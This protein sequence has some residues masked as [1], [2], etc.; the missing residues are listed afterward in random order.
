MEP[1]WNLPQ[2]SPDQ[3]EE[4]GEPWW[5]PRLEH[6][7]LVELGGTLVEP[8]LKPPRTKPSQMVEPWWNPGG[9]LVEPL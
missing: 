2:T 1:L 4:I 8:Y 7:G 5:N 6:K 3:L 9:N